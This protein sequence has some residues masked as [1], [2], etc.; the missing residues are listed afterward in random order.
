MESLEL[1][2]REFAERIGVTHPYLGDRYKYLKDFT[3]DDI[4]R[5]AAIFEIDPLDFIVEAERRAVLEGSYDI[6]HALAASDA[7]Y[8]NE[9]EGNLDLP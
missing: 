7:D 8:D 5:V 4:A 3:L 1:S 6:T 2:N 9:A